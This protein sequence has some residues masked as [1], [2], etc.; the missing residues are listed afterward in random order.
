[1]QSFSG[2]ESCALLQSCRIGVD[3]LPVYQEYFVA[4]LMSDRVLIAIYM[5]LP[6]MPW[7]FK[8]SSPSKLTELVRGDSEFSILGVF[9]G[10]GSSIFVV[11]NSFRVKAFLFRYTVPSCQSNAIPRNYSEVS[12][13][14]MTKLSLKLR[15]IASACF[16]ELT[17]TSKSST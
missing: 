8:A 16:S 13:S 4:T 1:M 11:N 12:G 5:R 14:F 15:F 6:T 10:L 7:N 9:I 2:T 17:S 3:F